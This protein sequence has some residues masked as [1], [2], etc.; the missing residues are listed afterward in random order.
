MPSEKQLCFDRLLRVTLSP[1]LLAYVSLHFCVVYR[2]IIVFLRFS[3]TFSDFLHLVG[4]EAVEFI[5]NHAEVSI[6]FV[7]DTK[8][9]LV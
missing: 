1:L 2:F 6:A 5:I 8:L 7:Q 3:H 4:N 9:D